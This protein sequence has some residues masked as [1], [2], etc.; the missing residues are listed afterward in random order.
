MFLEVLAGI[1]DYFGPVIDLR[2][3]KTFVCI[4]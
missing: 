4:V 2:K 3:A 1:Y